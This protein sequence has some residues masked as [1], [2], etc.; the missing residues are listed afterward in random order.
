M[1]DY[2][3]DADIFI[4]SKNEAYGFDLAPGFWKLIDQKAKEG[5]IASSIVVYRELIKGNDYLAEWA[6]QR[7]NSGLF[8]IPNEKVQD[9]NKLIVNYVN[10][11]YAPHKVQQFLKGADPWII[12]H[13]KI[14][15]GEVVT[16]ETHV[17]GDIKIP[18][19]ADKFHVKC[20][21]LWDLLRILHVS[22][23]ITNSTNKEPLEP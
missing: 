18:D 12:A 2:W 3:L 19:I 14:D 17:G 6:R 15:G 5:I 4:R 9:Q 7:E 1:A 16:F 23:D 20:I 22:F 11:T 13:A 8:I 21:N 10:R